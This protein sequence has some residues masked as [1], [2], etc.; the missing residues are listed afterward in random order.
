MIKNWELWGLGLLA[1]LFYVNG[2]CG[3]A[4]LC[5]A[6]LVVLPVARRP[7]KSPPGL[8]WPFV[9]CEVGPLSI[10][11]G[12]MVTGECRPGQMFVIDANGQHTA[13]VVTEIV[14][15]E[16][17]RPRWVAQDARSLREARWQP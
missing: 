5:L 7:T 14:S 17:G 13:M 3:W 9:V 1:T 6:A 15:G 16:N 10:R 12:G 8:A 11:A 2:L 4:I